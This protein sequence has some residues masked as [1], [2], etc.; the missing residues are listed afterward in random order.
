M[1]CIFNKL[2]VNSKAI[3]KHWY[4]VVVVLLIPA[5]WRQRQ[6]DGCE[7]QASQR[8]DK[9][10]PC[11]RKTKKKKHCSGTSFISSLLQSQSL[12]TSQTAFSPDPSM[13]CSSNPDDI[14]AVE[15]KIS[16][17]CSGSFWFF[18]FK[19]QKKKKVIVDRIITYQ[20]SYG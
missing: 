8:C 9:E 4:W 19:M 3:S 5:L 20:K 7:F 10:K 1:S 2:F 11:L 16:L 17:L 13:V 6:V 12:W 14:H 18:L 15:E